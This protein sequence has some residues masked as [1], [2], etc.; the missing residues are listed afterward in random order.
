M[1]IVSSLDGD[2]GARNAG[3]VL[4]VD[5]NGAVANESTG[6]A[7]QGEIGISVGHVNSGGVVGDLSILSRKV[8]NLA[9]L[10]RSSGARGGLS[11][12]IRVQV[13]LGSGA[14]AV[15]GDGLVVDVVGEVSLADREALEVENNLGSNGTGAGLE[16]NLSLDGAGVAGEDGGVDDIGGVARD[17]GSISKLAGLRLGEGDGGQ[18]EERGDSVELHCDDSVGFW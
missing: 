14:V 4:S 8:T 10:R 3:R 7:L 6:R 5:D 15:G 16:L 17:G 2:V 18:G 12:L 13:G 9:G 11:T 1:A